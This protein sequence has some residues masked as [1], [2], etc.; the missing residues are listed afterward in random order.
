MIKT[1]K[2]EDQPAQLYGISL[3]YNLFSL[4]W[5]VLLSKLPLQ[6]LN[7]PF[8]ELSSSIVRGKLFAFVKSSLQDQ[9]QRFRKDLLELNR[10]AKSNTVSP[11]LMEMITNARLPTEKPLHDAWKSFQNII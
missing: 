8:A 3:I 9:I 6:I 11:L 10:E 1:I 5:A 4:Q 2:A 7:F